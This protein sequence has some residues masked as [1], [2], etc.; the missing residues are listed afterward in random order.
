VRNIWICSAVVT[1]APRKKG[2]SFIIQK[3]RV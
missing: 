3:L 2:I 1:K